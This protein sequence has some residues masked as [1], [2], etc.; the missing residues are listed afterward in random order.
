MK[1]EFNYKNPYFYFLSIFSIILILSLSNIVNSKFA[2]Y[3]SIL[4][5]MICV[6]V[7]TIDL[8]YYYEIEKIQS[9][10]SDFGLAEK[11]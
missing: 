3:Y 6:L 11:T 7:W 2:L 9:S 4:G 8:Y 5:I 1:I 10:D